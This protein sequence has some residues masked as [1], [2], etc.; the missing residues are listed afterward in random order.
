[1]HKFEQCS[2]DWILTRARI[3]DDNGCKLTEPAKAIGEKRGGGGAARAFLSEWLKDFDGVFEIPSH[4][5]TL[6]AYSHRC[7]H[8]ENITM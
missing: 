6:M 1:M 2:S 5:P 8:G 3:I 4:G 7:E